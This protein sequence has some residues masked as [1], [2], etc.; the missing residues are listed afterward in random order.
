[1]AGSDTVS[2][3]I[4][5]DQKFM[6]AAEAAGHNVW[7]DLYGFE[8]NPDFTGE[9]GEEFDAA[10]EEVLHLVTQGYIA[11]FPNDFGTEPGSALTN[12]MD[13][14]RGGQFKAPPAKYPANAWYTYNDETCTYDCMAVEYFYW[15][16]TSMLGA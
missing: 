3:A 6:E 10:L 9:D 8:T 4:F 15:V 16:L 13:K 7:Q 2:S 12:A 14:A 11:K 1:M 5:E